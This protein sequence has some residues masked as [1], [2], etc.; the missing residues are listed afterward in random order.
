[1]TQAAFPSNSNDDLLKRLLGD[2]LTSTQ[3][4]QFSRT[5]HGPMPRG[6]GRL[7]YRKR[8]GHFQSAFVDTKKHIVFTSYYPNITLVKKSVALRKTG[9][10]HTTFIGCCVREDH[11]LERFFD[12]VY[13]VSDY[14]ELFSMMCQCGGF[15]LHAVSLPSVFGLAAVA[16][17]K[18]TGIRTLIDVN[19]A[20]LFIEKDVQSPSVVLERIM[21][22]SCDGFTHKMP[23]EAIDEMRHIW[24]GLPRDVQSHSLPETDFFAVSEAKQHRSVVFAGGLIPYDIAVKKGHEGHVF[25]PLIQGICQGHDPAMEF[26]VFVNQNARES[27]WEEHAHYLDYQAVYPGFHFYKGVPFFALPERICC[28]EYGLYYENFKASSYNPLHFKYNMPTKLFSYIEAGL[29]VLVPEHAEYIRSYAEKHGFA[30]IYRAE[31][32]RTIHRAVEKADYQKLAASVLSFR[33]A[34]SMDTGL[35]MLEAIYH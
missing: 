8:P 20:M 35:P 3:L 31:D 4:A 24:P 10:Y 19:D 6:R 1:M 18:A 25:D 14:W 13:E 23:A 21:L 15:A 11:C 7:H 29:P 34:R 22:E 26:S 12:D 16:A 9:R 33:R 30:V 28:F 17:R 5:L 27:Y 2:R 32:P